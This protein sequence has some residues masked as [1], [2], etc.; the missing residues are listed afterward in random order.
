MTTEKSLIKKKTIKES[1]TL[2]LL[3]NVKRPHT[4]QFTDSEYPEIWEL[5]AGS[6]MIRMANPVHLAA[7]NYVRQVKMVRYIAS[8]RQED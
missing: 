8:H 4:I 6:I 2:E 7:I 5:A 3:I 1:T